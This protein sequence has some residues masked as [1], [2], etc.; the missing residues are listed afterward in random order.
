[1]G[2]GR[3]LALHTWHCRRGDGDR[4]R[5]AISGGGS[6]CS[7]GAEMYCRS[8]GIP[9]MSMGGGGHSETEYVASVTASKLSDG[10]GLFILDIFRACRLRLSP[11]FQRR[12]KE[13]LP[14]I[15][16]QI[17]QEQIARCLSKE[18]KTANCCNLWS[19]RLGFHDLDGLY[20][21]VRN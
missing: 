13:A 15:L 4:E 17:F 1:M 12:R 18:M 10:P 8:E 11:E 14:Q 2:D 3:A 6:G 7:K 5:R 21:F 9:R 19:P 16:T 20:V